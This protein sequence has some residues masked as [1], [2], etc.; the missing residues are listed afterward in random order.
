MRSLATEATTISSSTEKLVD[1]QRE[2]REELSSWK[3]SLER[4]LQS[5]MHREILVIEERVSKSLLAEKQHI[6]G[7]VERL[8]RADVADPALVSLVE[9]ALVEAEAKKAGRVDY[10]ALANGASVMR[11]KRFVRAIELVG[12]FR[13]CS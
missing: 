2:L 8:K 12:G 3:A 4:E 11:S 6:L 7:S 9:G 1:R 10:A 13:W 5:G